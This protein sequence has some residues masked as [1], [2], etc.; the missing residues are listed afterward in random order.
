MSDKTF[1]ELAELKQANYPIHPVFDDI[2]RPISE[3]KKDKTVIWAVMYTDIYPRMSD[4]KEMVRWHGVQLPLFHRGVEKDS[5][6][7]G[8]EVAAPVGCGGFPDAW[9][10]G[11]M[12]LIKPPF[13]RYKEKN[14]NFIRNKVQE[15]ELQLQTWK[16]VLHDASS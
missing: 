8:W 14:I 6:D 13:G 3:A 15:L 9:I 11:W 16:E 10:A 5:V 12:P 2:W 4:V 1:Y 7:I